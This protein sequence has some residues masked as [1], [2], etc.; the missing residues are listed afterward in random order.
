MK[1]EE[2]GDESRKRVTVE[3]VIRVGMS[4]TYTCILAIPIS[5]AYAAYAVDYD[6]YI[7]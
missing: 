7:L 6:V 5:I 3:R 2:E 4:Y 1:I